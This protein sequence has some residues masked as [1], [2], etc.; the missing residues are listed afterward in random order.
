MPIKTSELQSVLKIAKNGLAS[1][2]IVDAG[3]VF[4]FQKDKIIT[5]NDHVS[6]Q[7]PFKSE[8]EVT[9]PADAFFKIISQ[10][11]SD[12]IILELDGENLSIR[13]GKVRSELSCPALDLEEI[14][15]PVDTAELDWKNLP[16]DFMEAIKNTVFSASADMTKPIF[17]CISVSK[18]GIHSTDNLRI[19]EFLFSKGNF[20]DSFLLP[21]TASYLLLSVLPSAEKF[22]HSESWIFFKDSTETVFAIKEVEGE[23][24]DVTSFFEVDGTQIDLP[25]ELSESIETA[26]ILAEGEFA[27][28][29]KITVTYK[30]GKITCKGETAGSGWVSST[31]PCQTKDE[32]SFQINPVFFKEILSKCKTAIH[33]DS[34]LLFTADNFRHTVSL[35]EGE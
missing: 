5:Y 15:S 18:K 34:V 11:K 24:P 8:L 35:F 13:S 1:K 14:L 23:F 6:V 21:A 27:F 16:S 28:D 3:K 25:P 31:V 2:D 12:E 19:S 9:A 29:K 17:T 26:S 7:V 30:K 33:S 10:L 4:I 22:A 32:L 20:K